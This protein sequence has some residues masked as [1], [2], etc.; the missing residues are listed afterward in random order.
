[1]TLPKGAVE[2]LKK[3]EE[4]G[5]C[6]FGDYTDIEIEG[7]NLSSATVN[8][9]LKELVALDALEESVKRS[10]TGRKTVGY[11][12]TQRGQKIVRIAKEYAEK[13]E[14]IE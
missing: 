6:S 2:I 9:R 10:D 3:T 1:M 11:E 4:I 14:E 5:K 13:M 7:E 8:K 12:I